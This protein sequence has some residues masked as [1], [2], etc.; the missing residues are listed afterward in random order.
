MLV[1][2]FV[3]LFFLMT[4]LLHKI[5]AIEFAVQVVEFVLLVDHVQVVWVV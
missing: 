4:D 5:V 3:S 2:S 1:L